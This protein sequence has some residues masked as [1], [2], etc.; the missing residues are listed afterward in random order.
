[1]A[2]R[3]RDYYVSTDPNTES[4]YDFANSNHTMF[5]MDDGI[6]MPEGAF[7]DAVP[8]TTFEL[9]AQELGINLAASPFATESFSAEAGSHAVNPTHEQESREVAFQE[10]ETVGKLPTNRPLVKA[11]EWASSNI[12]MT[13]GGL[14]FLGICIYGLATVRALGKQMAEL[15]TMNRDGR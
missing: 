10:R 13:V 8:G 3:M 5:V 6:T 9:S 1:M 14:A 7:R 2:N 12:G 11:A 15:K 4:R